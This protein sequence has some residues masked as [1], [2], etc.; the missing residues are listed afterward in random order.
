MKNVSKGRSKKIRI[1]GQRELDQM[2]HESMI[3]D[4]KIFVL[5]ISL[6]EFRDEALKNEENI[7]VLIL[8]SNILIFY[9]G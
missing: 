1:V 8:K 6:D 2:E 9:E 3:K 5:E 4:K 7:T